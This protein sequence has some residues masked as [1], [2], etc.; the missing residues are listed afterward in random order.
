VIK[1][2]FGVETE[3]LTMAEIAQQMQ[4][5]RERVRQIRDTALRKLRKAAKNEE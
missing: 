3:H 1:N 5:K 2:Y 4:L